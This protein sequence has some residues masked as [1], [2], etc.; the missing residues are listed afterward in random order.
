LKSGLVNTTELGWY[1]TSCPRFGF[2]PGHSGWYETPSKSLSVAM[3]PV[4]GTRSESAALKQPS[5][6]PSSSDSLLLVHSPP[7]DAMALQYSKCPI[8][9]EKA[10]L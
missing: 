6:S 2:V 8:S 5:S 4:I 1:F 9:S 7:S 10:T 3:Q